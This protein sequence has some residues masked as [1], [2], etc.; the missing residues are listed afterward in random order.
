LN[1]IESKQLKGE[2]L[3]ALNLK[4]IDLDFDF[5]YDISG[6]FIAKFANL[7]LVKNIIIRTVKNSVKSML[8]NSIKNNINNFLQNFILSLPPYFG[9]D[10]SGLALNYGILNKPTISND[11]FLT[12]N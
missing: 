7:S 11:S 3:P 10:K 5:T 9:L 8:A 6:D 2:M 4:K 1:E 12:L